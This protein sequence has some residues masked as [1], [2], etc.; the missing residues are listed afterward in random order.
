MSL[1]TAQ[2]PSAHDPAG[3]QPS[4]DAVT[5]GDGAWESQRAAIR[6]Q[7]EA[8][9]AEARPHPLARRTLALLV[10]AE[11]DVIAEPPSYRV[12]DRRGTARQSPDNEGPETLADLVGRLRS[13]H[14]ALFQ[15]AEPE[16]VVADDPQPPAPAAEGAATRVWTEQSARA[17]S[18]V[19]AS[20]TRART[21]A[22]SARARLTQVRTRVEERFTPAP[23]AEGGAG[24]AD[25]AV[26]PAPTG[27]LS[28]KA[29]RLG[30]QA[31]VAASRLRDRVGA[32]SAAAAARGR[33][34]WDDT[35]DALG[36]GGILRRPSTI[37][38]LA[39]IGIL[40]VVV[41]A[42]R[43]DGSDVAQIPASVPE[44]APATPPSAQVKPGPAD[45]APASAGPV[46]DPAPA[47]PPVP[48]DEPAPDDA[49]MQAEAAPQAGEI[50]GPAEVIDTA[51]LKIGGRVVRLFG[52]VWVRGGQREELAR[53][54]GK[55]PVTCQP[56]P[57]SDAHLCSVDGRD[58]SEVVLFNGGGRAS[59]E[60]TPD[61]VAAEDRA[62]SER[63]GVWAR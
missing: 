14:P 58:L 49:P 24:S 57:G 22:M 23:P 45:P 4:D 59:P 12:V 2:D 32:M 13:R 34:G 8:A 60:A 63:L 3:A 5:G 27:D 52:V 9:V 37:A 62:R 26:P 6:A 18:L 43:D 48:D 20:G 29:D 54:L 53:Y 16:P 41:L 19:A 11:V 39:G 55:R 21:L 44:T 15:P 30:G 17:R 40:A 25:L 61:L 33:L 28:V 31:R 50:A 7:I 36:A 56:V 1:D 10:E 51:T 46:P 35:R 42:I 38:A 47:K